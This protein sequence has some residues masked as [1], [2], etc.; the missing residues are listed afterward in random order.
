[1]ID[2]GARFKGYCADLTR[3]FYLGKI[4]GFY[5]QIYQVVREAKAAAQALVKPGVT[6]S[7]IDEAARAVFKGAGY[8]KFFVH[9]TG[10]GVGIDVHELPLIGPHSNMVLKP[11]MVITI[12]PG[13]YVP[14]RCGVRIE[15]TLL[16]TPEGSE[17]LTR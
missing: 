5:S 8:E 7:K 14:R 2:A 13:L 11:G 9:S 4:D 10:H 1:M 15:D 3:M 16:V 6:V 17:I 12:E